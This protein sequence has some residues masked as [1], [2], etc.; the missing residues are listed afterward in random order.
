MKIKDERLY[1]LRDV[2]DILGISYSFLDKA[3]RED[4][5]MG[6]VKIGTR[7]MLPGKVVKRILKEGIE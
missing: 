3:C 2:C 6:V 5:V 7:R 1:K 4:R